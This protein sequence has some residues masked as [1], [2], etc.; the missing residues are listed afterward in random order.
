ML[1]YLA[2]Q[3]GAEFAAALDTVTPEG[4]LAHMDSQGV[5]KAVLLAEYSPKTTG[6]IPNEF[7]SGF[8]SESER[9][10]PF[11]S[12]DVDSRVPTDEQVE[13][14]VTQMGCKGI[15]LVPS[16]IGR[17]PDDP[18]LQPVY[19][20]ARDLG[21]PV[22]FH[23]G[24]SLFP[25]S[26]IRYADPLLLDGI[27]DEFSDL[28]IIMCHAGRPFW[29]REAEWMLNRHKNMM[30]DISGI[31]PKQIPIVL[32]KMDKFRDR[33]IFGSDWPLSPP[34]A[35]LVKQ[36]TELP[37]SPSTIEAVLWENGARLLKET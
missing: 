29:Y 24:T 14:C 34:V 36:V 19:A 11:G 13:V 23:T 31:P 17:F 27:A 33:F 5:E 25:G 21:V 28:V 30:V 3:I 26:R 37:L 20:T 6:V 35:Q 16:Y 32:P 1:S 18:C 9:L 7:T 22:M 12:V 4:L 15:K 8:C 10:I 2:E